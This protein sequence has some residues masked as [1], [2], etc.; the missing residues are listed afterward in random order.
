LGGIKAK[1][2][3]EYIYFVSRLDGKPRVFKSDLFG[4]ITSDN[5]T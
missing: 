1:L 3:E 2:N 5:S 4:S